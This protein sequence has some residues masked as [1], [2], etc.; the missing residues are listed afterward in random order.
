MYY[1]HFE[2]GLLCSLLDPD[3]PL[4]RKPAGSTLG[5]TMFILPFRKGA[6]GQGMV[7]SLSCVLRVE[8]TTV[9]LPAMWHMQDPHALLLIANLYVSTCA[10]LLPG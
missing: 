8:E 6:I 10:S 7:R 9:Y 2:P 5:I 1:E 4:T 3:N